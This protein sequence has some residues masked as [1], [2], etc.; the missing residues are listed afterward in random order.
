M[1]RIEITIRPPVPADL[2]ALYA[3]HAD[4]RTNVYNPAAGTSTLADAQLRLTEWLADWRLQGIGYWTVTDDL[5]E[6]IG[7]VG[8]RILATPTGEL[9]NLYYRLKPRV[10]GRGV[11]RDAAGRAVALGR[12]RFPELAVVARAN[13]DN[14]PSI[15]V[16]EAIGLTTVGADHA[17]RIVLADRPLSARVLASLP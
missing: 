12:E 15:R 2:D 17:G 9:L 4:P 1:Q 16:A 7:F 5:D 6:V 8:V 10:W 14:L 11:A 3:V 13:P